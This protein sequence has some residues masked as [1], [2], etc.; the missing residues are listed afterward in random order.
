MDLDPVSVQNCVRL[1]LPLTIDSAPGEVRDTPGMPLNGF[2]AQRET[3]RLQG[4]VCRHDRDE[5]DDLISERFALVSG[6]SLGRLGKED[7]IAAALQVEWKSFDV[8]VSRVIDLG[9]AVVVDHDIEQ[10]M[11]AAPNWASAAPTRT[12]WITTDVWVVEGGRWRLVCRHPELM[13]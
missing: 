11:A 10:D 2:D 5:L 7:W 4:A 6:R 9:D 12:R 8:W 1:R 13:Q 3:D